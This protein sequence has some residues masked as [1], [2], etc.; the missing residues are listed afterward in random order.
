MSFSYRVL[1][2]LLFLGS[3]PHWTTADLN[4]IFMINR[5]TDPE[6]QGPSAFKFKNG[7]FQCF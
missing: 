4:T 5:L 3:A 1:R 2:S 7:H 6:A